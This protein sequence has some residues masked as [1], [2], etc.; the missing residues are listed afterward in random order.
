LKAS[1]WLI[2][3]LLLSV[4]LTGG[5]AF[6]EQGEPRPVMHRIESRPAANAVATAHPLATRAALAMLERGGSP[7]DA[8]IAAQMVLGAVEPQSSGIGGGVLLMIWD[9]ASSTLTSFDGLAVAPAT[10]TAGLNVDVDG[11]PLPR[12]RVRRGGRSVGVP[13]A[14][15]ALKAAHDRYGKLSWAALFAPAIRLAEEGFSLSPYLHGLLSADNAARLHPDLVPLYFGADGKVL[16]VGTVV[17]NPAYAQTLRRIA[18]QGPQG[19]LDEGGA[20][21]I[22]AAAQRGFRPS[23]MTE[24]DLHAARAVER[25]PVCAP[26]LS[27]RVCAMAPPSHGGVVVL[28]ILQMLE[29]LGVKRYD[30]DDPAFVH[31]YLEAGRL[32]QADRRRFVGDPGFV[33]VPVGALLS[34]DYL[35]RRAQLIDMTQANPRPTPGSPVA[36]FAEVDSD[37]NEQGPA[38]SQLAIADA[39]GNVLSMTTTINLNFGS[40]LMVDGYVLNNALNLFSSAPQPGRRVANQ[41]APGKRPS[42][43]MAPTIVFDSAGRVVAAGGSA[44][45]PYIPDYIAVSLIEM[46][47]NGR[48]P[49]QAL[50]RGHVSSAAPMN[51][52][53]VERGTAAEDLLPVLA[54]KGHDIEVRSMRSGQG[55]LL[56]RED[57][58]L[59]AADARRDG[60]AEGW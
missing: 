29:A 6:V 35:R 57:G 39:Q 5:C 47:A 55:F 41:M 50:A 18:A 20:A 30:F 49:A 32:A 33:D 60:V 7:V 27:Y 9:E 36:T 4:M 16:P 59:G 51:K 53:R 38:T 26:F 56:R 24:Q 10:V 12:E 22:V 8:A 28:Q 17:R 31:Q 11:S 45:G 14:L 42:T 46:L 15:P 21:R 40:R 43:S 1:H 54:D 37:T 19:M 13:G 58:W 25:T 2:A 23:L 44:G 34:G 52:V 48:T 3:S